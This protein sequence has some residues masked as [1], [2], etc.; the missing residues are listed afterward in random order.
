MPTPNL[1]SF[2]YNPPYGDHMAFCPDGNLQVDRRAAEDARTARNELLAFAV[3]QSTRILDLVR[4]AGLRPGSK[5]YRR[6]RPTVTLASR[7]QPRFLSK[8]MDES[9]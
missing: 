2:S 4:P 3:N 5:G 1:A 6:A 8:P 7:E 9:G